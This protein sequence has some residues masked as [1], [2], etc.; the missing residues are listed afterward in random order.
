M[1]KTIPVAKERSA[2]NQTNWKQVKIREG[3]EAV[4]VV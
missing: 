2:S 1:K 4:G 3:V